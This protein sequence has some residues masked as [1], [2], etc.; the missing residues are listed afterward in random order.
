MGSY[1]ISVG[2]VQDW[3]RGSTIK[4]PADAL[5]GARDETRGMD[6]GVNASI[7]ILFRYIKVSNVLDTSPRISDG[8]DKVEMFN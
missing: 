3:T 8:S 6:A 5:G 4:D 2:A 1:T 7:A